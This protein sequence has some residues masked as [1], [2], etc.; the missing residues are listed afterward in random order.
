MAVSYIL[1]GVLVLVSIPLLLCISRAEKYADYVNAVDK[2]KISSAKYIGLGFACIDMLKID[3]HKIKYARQREQA[4]ILFGK[5]F[6]DFY[7]RVLYA[8]AFTY[9]FIILYAA[10]FLSCLVGGPDGILLSVLGAVMAVAVYYYYLGVYKGKI[11]K[12]SEEY[13]TEFPGAVSTIALL[14]NGGVFLRDAW[15]DVAYSSDKPLFMQMRKV[16]E[17]MN[18]GYSEADA[19]TMFADRCSTKEIRKFASIIVQAISKGGKD[20][21]DSLIKQSDSLLNAK[22]QLVLQKGEKASSKLLI[23]IMLVFV[24]ILIMVM[25]PVMSGMSV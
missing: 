14:V 18:N 10:V 17:D 6:A 19:I 11:E 3:F 12:L 5:K 4:G 22:R 2:S 23:P 20:L 25:V 13:M 8:Q 1:L 15:K 21:A 24:S 7:L 16:V 9:G